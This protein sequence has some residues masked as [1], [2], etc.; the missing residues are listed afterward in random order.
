MAESIDFLVVDLKRSISW[1]QV[2]EGWT[3]Q[4]EA[5]SKERI[6]TVRGLSESK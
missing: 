2:S 5:G 1:N 4:G 3:E 6:R